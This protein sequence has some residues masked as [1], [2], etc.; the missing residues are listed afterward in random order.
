[1]KL[2]LSCKSSRLIFVVVTLPL[3]IAAFYYCSGDSDC[4]FTSCCFLHTP[5][6]SLLHLIPYRCEECCGLMYTKGKVNNS[7]FLTQDCFE[8]GC[9]GH[10][11]I[12][13]LFLNHDKWWRNGGRRESLSSVILSLWTLQGINNLHLSIFQSPWLA[14][15]HPG[16]KVVPC[17]Y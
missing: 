2:I 17:G 8:M 13:C 16:L 10:H 1:M 6:V 3:W 15:R 4:S 11:I 5:V 12:S 7:T 9:T 14:A